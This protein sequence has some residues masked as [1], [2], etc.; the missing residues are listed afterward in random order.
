M[1]IQPKHFIPTE[2]FNRQLLNLVVAL[3]F[4]L[5]QSL[6][7]R[8]EHGILA[9]VHAREKIAPKSLFKLLRLRTAADI[10][11]YQVLPKFVKY[12]QD[13]ETTRNH[14]G[15]INGLVNREAVRVVRFPAKHAIVRS[16]R[17]QR[18]EI[19]LVQQVQEDH[20]RVYACHV[21]DVFHAATHDVAAEEVVPRPLA[22]VATLGQDGDE[23][24]NNP[25]EGGDLEGVTMTSHYSFD[26]R[27]TKKETR[28]LR[29]SRCSLQ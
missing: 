7:E 18:A 11:T 29:L 3:T 27:W 26:A 9:N 24:R 28:Y 10:Q 13:D 21:A 1:N 23:A 5:T 22:H 17:P 6:I 14:S 4:L 20:L 16:L 8:V 19:F 15:K 25:C 2:G 12:L